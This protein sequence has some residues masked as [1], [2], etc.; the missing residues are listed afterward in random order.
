MDPVLARREI[1]GKTRTPWIFAFITTGILV[2][3]WSS[4]FIA[5]IIKRTLKPS[6]KRN[7]SPEKQKLAPQPAY[8]VP[9][10]PAL[11]DCEETGLGLDPE[12]ARELFSKENGSKVHCDPKD[13]GVVMSTNIPAT[14][15]SSSTAPL[16]VN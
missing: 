3:I 16:N 8:I 2:L 9:P 1:L 11:M 13:D 12:K 5:W 15:A 14:P 10:D 7:A 6:G 4:I